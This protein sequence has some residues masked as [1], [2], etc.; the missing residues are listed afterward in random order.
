MTYITYPQG[1]HV[2]EP[3]RAIIHKIVGVLPPASLAPWEALTE[4]ASLD[5][6]YA[7]YE[8]VCDWVNRNH[9]RIGWLT[10]GGVVDAAV[11]LVDRALE[12]GN[13]REVSDEVQIYLAWSDD[14]EG[15]LDVEDDHN[16]RIY[17]PPA[18]VDGFIGDLSESF[19]VELFDAGEAQSCGIDSV[20]WN[21]WVG[22]LYEAGEL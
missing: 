15:W 7:T 1:E 6:D 3:L 18:S 20:K 22:A 21:E 12:N 8:A 17:I 5:D 19:S 11:L 13:L 14:W 4:F 16:T 2:P 10:N 9:K